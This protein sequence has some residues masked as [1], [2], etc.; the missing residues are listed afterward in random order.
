MIMR[1]NGQ[2]SAYLFLLKK[3][4]YVRLEQPQK[5]KDKCHQHN[6]IINKSNRTQTKTETFIIYT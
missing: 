4:A 2:G 3:S 5:Q 1:V 6:K